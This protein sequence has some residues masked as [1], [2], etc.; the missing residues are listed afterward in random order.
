MCDSALYCLRDDCDD[1]PNLR[2]VAGLPALK[3]NFEA[4]S[5]QNDSTRTQIQTETDE[6]IRVA[7]GRVAAGPPASAEPSVTL[8]EQ[9]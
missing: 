4:Q 1:E 7:F 6:E 5:T 3:N 8:K 2:E 9:G